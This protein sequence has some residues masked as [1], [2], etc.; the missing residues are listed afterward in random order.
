MLIEFD[1]KY[2]MRKSAKGRAISEFLADQTVEGHG[3]KEFSFLDNELM[4]I[5]Q[6]T[7]KVYFD[8]VTN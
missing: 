8:G 1:L 6:D 3:I 7:L 4:N 2:I 5:A